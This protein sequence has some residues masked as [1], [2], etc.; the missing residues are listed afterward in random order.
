MLEKLILSPPGGGQEINPAGRK[1]VLKYTNIW[2]NDIDI[3]NIV[4]LRI[5]LHVY[6]I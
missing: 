1:G 5:V 2:N 4:E 6:M 3:K